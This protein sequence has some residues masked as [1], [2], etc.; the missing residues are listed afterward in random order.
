MEINIHLKNLA[1][2]KLKFLK[3]KNPNDLSAPEKY[4]AAVISEGS[5]NLKRLAEKIAYQSTLTPGDCYN[6]L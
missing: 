1:M 3:R 2:I 6:V 4:Y 5:I